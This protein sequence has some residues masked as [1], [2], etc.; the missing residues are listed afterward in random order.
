MHPRVLIVGTVPYNENTTSRAFAAYFGN[1]E[2]DNLRQVFSDPRKPFKGHCSSLYQITDKQ[3]L[4]RRLGKIKDTGVIYN[5]DDLFDPSAPAEISGDNGGLIAALYKLGKNKT[6]LNRLARGFL[7]A[8][9]YWNTQKFRDWLDEFSPE[10]VF[11]AFSDDFFINEI[12]LFVADR[13]NIPIMACVGDDYYFND[14]KSLSPLYRVYRKKYKKLI[15]R[16]FSHPSSA[17][18]ISDKIRDKYNAAFSIEGE[19]VYLNSSLDRKPFSVVDRASPKI[20]YCGNV[21]LGRE[22]S[23]VKIANALA[24]INDSYKIE[25]YTAEKDEKYLAP[26]KK[27]KNIAFMGEADYQTVKRVFKE[28]DVALLVEGFDEKSVSLTRYSL[29]TKAADSVCSGCQIFAFGSKECGLIEYIA[30]TGCAVVV[31]DESQ[32]EKEL[33]KLLTDEKL[34]KDLYDR[35]AVVA[36]QNHDL[37]VGYARVE[38]LFE[39]LV[40]GDKHE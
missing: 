38:R 18:Y 2:R 17:I 26:L 15:D 14:E 5:Y 30:S 3:M 8:E 16:V 25:V 12:A 6:P 20:S 1:W 9:K 21:R 4:F 36:K 33:Y 23:L 22:L 29:S 32:L 10:C 7:W 37:S 31:T 19:T 11:L 34:Q 27:C 28:T 13:F 39:K 40:G 24:K 35:S